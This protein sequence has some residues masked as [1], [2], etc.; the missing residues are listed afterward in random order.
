MAFSIPH[1]H[2]C[3]PRRAHPPAD[4]R[5]AA[6]VGAQ[7]RRAGRQ[8][9]DQPA[10]RVQAPQG[11]ARRRPRLVPRRGAAAHLPAR[12]RALRIA[13]RLADALSPHVERAARR[14][15]APPRRPGGTM[16]FHPSPPA[17]ARCI[18]EGDRRTLIFVRD[19]GHPAEKVWAALT[20]PAQLRAWSPYVADRDLGAPGDATATMMDGDEEADRLPLTVV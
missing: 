17:D 16:S 6:L 7:C 10:D 19:L 5:R 18:A 12:K 20:D 3:R 15:R 4:P 11:A 13:R 1:G 9:L 8:A 2:L 14:A